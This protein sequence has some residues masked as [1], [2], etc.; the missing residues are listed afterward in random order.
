MPKMTILAPFSMSS[1][2]VLHHHN[3]PQNNSIL[4]HNCYLEAKNIVQSENFEK[5]QV[6][7][8]AISH[9]G[10]LCIKTLNDLGQMKKFKKNFNFRFSSLL[11]T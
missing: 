1:F 4:I 9:I 6:L 2:F 5:S 8:F 11:Y 10:V 7:Y 3:V